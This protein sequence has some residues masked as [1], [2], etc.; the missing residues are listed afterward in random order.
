MD[1]VL[2]QALVASSFLSAGALDPQ[3]SVL[4][5]FL[6]REPTLDPEPAD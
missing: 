3:A 2:A 5:S 6:S 1:L 4:A